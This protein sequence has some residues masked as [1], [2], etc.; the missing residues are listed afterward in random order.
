MI[1]FTFGPF[2]PGSPKKE[3]KSDLGANYFVYSLISGGF[4]G[5][6]TWSAA[7]SIGYMVDVRDAA[8]AVRHF[9]IHSLTYHY[10]RLSSLR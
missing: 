2:V 3:K 10:Q 9:L 5:P 7:F 4:E 6:S 8:K 1:P